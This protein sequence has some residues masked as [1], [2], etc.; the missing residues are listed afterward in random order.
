MPSEH[1]KVEDLPFCTPAA[2]EAFGKAN[3][4]MIVTKSEGSFV[5]GC[6]NVRRIEI[7]SCT[8]PAQ[9]LLELAGIWENCEID[10]RVQ[11]DGRRAV[12]T[13]FIDADAGKVLMFGIES[14]PLMRA[15]SDPR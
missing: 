5:P 6:A 7:D 11:Y 9:T 1:I 8:V 15:K 3:P 12:L 2:L 4:E 13:F 10:E 14:L